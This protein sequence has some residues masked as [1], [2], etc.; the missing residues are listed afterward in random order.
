MKKVLFILLLFPLLSFSQKQGNIWYFG[1]HAGVDFNS[2]SPVVL[3]DGQTYL[4]TGTNAHCEGTSI[5]CDNSGSLLFYCNNKK[6]WNRNHQIMTYGGNL[7]SSVSATQGS[8]IVPKPGSSRYFYIFTVDDFQIDQLYFGFRY[9]LV[10]MCLNSGLGDVVNGQMNIKILDTVAEK[11]TA[12]RHAN[13]TDYWIIVHKFFSNAFYSYRLSST[14]LAA[15]VI[16]HV[17]SV[18][19]T[20]PILPPLIPYGAAAIG[21]LKASPNGQKLAIV[22]AN[23]G[24]NIA[25]YFDF[26]KNTGVVSNG[27]NIQSYPTWN[28]YGV[29]FSPDNSK[30]YISAIANITGVLQFDLNAGGGNPDSVN[31][32]RICVSTSDPF[33]FGLQLATN[34]KIYAAESPLNNNSYLAVIN[35]PNNK[36]LSCNFVNNAVDLNGHIASYGLPNFI[37]SYDYSNTTVNCIENIE[38]NKDQKIS[39]SPNPFST[40]TQITLPQSYH[41]ISL[42]VYDI[43][44]KLVFQN[45][46]NNTDKIILN[47]NKLNNGMYFLKLVLD[48]KGVKTGKI[49]VND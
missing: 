34:G 22:C 44:G 49:M 1:D 16:S 27:V 14:G 35:Y 39:I 6:V 43:Q 38:E 7:L 37:D 41:H 2:G 9:S 29:S 30:L 21:Q 13:G 36:G 24:Y 46:Y 12:V 8:L 48:E 45:Q 42:S 18:H 31:A 11:L 17:G 47:R 5:M 10:D 23:S 4:T 33:F 32:S 25:E 20:N 19:P 15:P 26:N 40:S 28:Y 3:N